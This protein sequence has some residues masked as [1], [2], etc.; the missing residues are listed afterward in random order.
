MISIVDFSPDM[1]L[2]HNTAHTARLLIDKLNNLHE[3]TNENRPNGG[4]L[5]NEKRAV[6]AYA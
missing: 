1:P 2:R 5:D 4:C 6:A 3:N